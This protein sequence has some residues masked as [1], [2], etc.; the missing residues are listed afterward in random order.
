[1]EL[2][3]RETLIV[4]I[5][6]EPIGVVKQGINLYSLIF[7]LFGNI[8]R[9][10]SNILT[11]LLLKFMNKI[12]KTLSVVAVVIIFG[13][14]FLSIILVSLSGARNRASTPSTQISSTPS[15]LTEPLWKEMSG[16]MN[17]QETLRLVIKTG[18]ISMVVKDINGTVK[19]IS[20]YAESK[21]G[22]VVSSNITGGEQTPS[23]NIVV[24]VPA[25]NFDEA[26][27][28]FKGLA[29]KISHESTQGQDVTEEYT[30]LQ[31]RLRNLEATENQLLG[32]MERSGTITDVLAVQREL[33]NVRNQIEQIKGRMQYLEK[34]AEMAT[35]TI[36]LALS[37]ELLPIP[38]AEKWQPV[39]V[40]KR[41][42]RSLLGSL[43][44]ISYILIWVG[45]YAIIWVPLG[46]VII[47]GR[48]FW[49]KMKETGK[50]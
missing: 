11:I 32:I 19:N 43:R 13:G 31:S 26:R 17:A 46:F 36:N 49:K 15:G 29:E 45:T 23:G 9:K 24:R 10:R 50:I 2:S 41:A 18:T 42:W 8:K 48:K 5:S 34:N 30:D 28:Y 1:M 6:F 7:V 16:E 20:Q 33:T 25:T 40:I 21:G 35:I 3:I 37:E 4:R 44:S 39:Y 38:P 22:W 27:A 47:W 12:L 14:I